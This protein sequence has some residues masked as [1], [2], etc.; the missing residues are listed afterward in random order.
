[1]FARNFYIQYSYNTKLPIMRRD[2][3]LIKQEEKEGFNNFL[4]QWRIKATY[5]VETPSGTDQS[6]V[7]Y[8]ES[9]A[10]I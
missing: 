1:M 5:T 6:E 8:Q 2:L 10:H 4:S 9:I 7:V 3:E